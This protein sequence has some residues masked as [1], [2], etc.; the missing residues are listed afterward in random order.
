MRMGSFVPFVVKH[1]KRTR[2]TQARFKRYGAGFVCAT[3]RAVHFD[4]VGDLSAD[5]LYL[6]LIRFMTKREKPKTIWTHNSTNFL[7]AERELSNSLENINQ[8]K[9]DN[10]LINK[11]PCNFNP[12]RSPW[13]GGSCDSI[14]KLTKR[15]LKLVLKDRPVYEGSS[16][17]FMINVEFTL[18]SHPILPL[19]D[20]INNLDAL[21]SNYFLISAHRLYFNPH[22]NCEKIY[23]RIRWK[24]VQA[25]SKILGDLF[26]KEYLPSLQI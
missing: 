17:A 22:M 19:S 13:I 3:T 8:T 16:R 20:E 2:T 26:V 14:I 10:F 9:F 18:N 6:A 4:L 24:A 7:G 23:G 15:S 21:K 5:R 12:S 11:V 1:S 25:L